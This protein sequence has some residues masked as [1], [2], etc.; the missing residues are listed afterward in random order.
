[1]KKTITRVALAA[2][3]MFPS[4][5]YNQVLQKAGKTVTTVNKGTAGTVFNLSPNLHHHHDGEHCISD[6]LTNQWINEYGIVDQYRAEQDHGNLIANKTTGSSDRATYTIPIIFHVIHNPDNP[7]EN[8]SEAAINAL[9][10]AVNEDFSA[11]NSDVG[12]LRSGFGWS[13]ANADIQFCLAQKDPQGQQ[14]SELGIHRVST[15]EDYYDPNT[16]ANKMKSSTSGNTGTEVWDRTSY[17][18]VWICDI[19]NGASSGTA[20]YA[21]KPTISSLPPASIDGIVIDYNLGMPPTNRVLTH[22][23]GHYLGLSHTWGN[24]NQSSGCTDD[25]GL[26]DTPNTAGPS[27]DYPGSCSGSQ[28]TCSGTETQ[29]EN[30][31]D[32][33]NCTIIYTQD[34]VDLMTAVLT[35]SRNSLNSSDACVPV[36]PQ[37]PVAN[38]VADITTTVE[39]GSV[40][41]TDLSTNYPTS[42]AWSV[43][44]ATGVTYINGTDAS[45][46]DPT[47]QFA[48]AGTYTVTLTASNI[49]G[50]D[51]EIKTDYITVVASGGGTTACDTLRNY[52]AAEEANMTAYGLTS[53]DGY[54]PGHVYLPPGTNAFQLQFIA[55]SFNVS[56]PTEVRRIYLP[57]FQADDIG[58]ANDV[59]FTVWDDNGATPGPGAVLG[60]QTVAISSLNAGFW[61][62]IDFAVPV[63][64]SGE[65]WV[66][67]ELEYPT[68]TIQDTVLFATTNFSDRPP[69][70]S[71][72]WVRGYE[73]LIPAQYT[74]QSTNS[75]FTSNPNCSLV[76]DV[77]TSNGPTPVAL[78]AW[79]DNETCEGM[80]VTMNGYGSSN[81][82]NYF[83]DISDGSNDY[84]YDE[85]NLTTNFFTQGTWTISLEADGSCLTDVDGPFTLTVNPPLNPNFSVTD[86]NCT[87]QDGA[88]NITIT[89][90]TGG[91]YNYSINNGTTI[92]TTG[93][94]TGLIAGTYNYI[95]SDNANCEATGTVTVGNVNT[96]AP[97]ITPDMTIAA[98]TPT[99]LTV[100]GGVS[101]TWYANEGAGPIQVGTTQT[102]NVAPTVTTTYVCNVTDGSGCDAELTVVITVDAGGGFDDLWSNQ[103]EMYPNPTS[104]EFSLIFGLNEA[105]D[106]NIEI[107]NVIGQKV[108]SNSFNQVKDQ[109]INFDLTGVASGVY[110]VNIQSEGETISKKIVVK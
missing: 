73:P 72:T 2:L 52:T 41:F 49:Y 69:G 74:W 14:L 23:L 56:T 30:F 80:S 42:W 106:M 98:G 35:G 65:F 66:G 45:S 59:I 34:Q 81:T 94:Y 11:T 22:E 68:T 95:L 99:D 4:M 10:D 8:V 26:S 40:N 44:P 20:G 16:E 79:P 6:A 78:A 101:W 102:I 25:D 75:L 3:I 76:M 91:P 71:T 46:Q 84:F 64:V 48:T 92:E 86:E 97:T 85:A 58:G 39:G 103:F 15:T 62:Q 100:T 108:F 96:F 107:L 109:T 12:N 54:Y 33:A 9:L 104:G 43:T 27:F 87:A 53:G 67:M 60:T 88:I 19:T 18:N 55:D 63:P 89:G 37:P 57:V 93:S 29:Y 32:Y 50:S 83:W 24:S 38:F 17:V 36:N 5:A 105:R 82:T 61:N 77:L 51:D 90:G 110:F 31:M 47:I 70:A 28:Q 1:M 7:A 13:A 21:Y